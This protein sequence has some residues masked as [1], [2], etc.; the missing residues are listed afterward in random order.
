MFAA[1]QLSVQKVGDSVPD[2]VT[3]WSSYRFANQGTKYTSRMRTRISS[4]R[5]K[6]QVSMDRVW[7]D[8]YKP[9]E[10]FLFLRRL[11]RA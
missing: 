1:F 3:D 7:F 4:N 9:A 6:F 2:N 11:V 5:K 10:L 8:G